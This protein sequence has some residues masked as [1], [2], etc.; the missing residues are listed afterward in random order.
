MAPPGWR[1]V[2]RGRTFPTPYPHSRIDHLL[3]TPAV[4][5]RSIE[6]VEERGSDHRPIRARLAVGGS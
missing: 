6:V 4:E 5:V 2:G 3:V 1:R